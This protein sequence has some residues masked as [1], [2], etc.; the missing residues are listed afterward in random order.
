VAEPYAKEYR[1]GAALVLFE[2]AIRIHQGTCPMLRPAI[3]G[4]GV[5]P[6]CAVTH[7]LFPGFQLLTI[8]PT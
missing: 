4:A 7:M 1:E 2:A 5:G 3:A 6:L 8:F